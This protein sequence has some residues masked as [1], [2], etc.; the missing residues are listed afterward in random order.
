MWLS[1]MIESSELQS[2][3]PMKCMPVP[4]E[5]LSVVW[6]YIVPLMVPYW[7]L[8]STLK[9][10]WGLVLENVSINLIRFVVADFFFVLFP[11]KA[12][13]QYMWNW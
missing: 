6:M 8:L 13:H 10:L 11:F 3:L 9:T 2:A 7:D 5:K 1:F 12:G 4:D